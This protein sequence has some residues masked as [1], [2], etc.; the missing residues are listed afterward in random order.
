L[1]PGIRTGRDLQNLA[2][3]VNGCLVAELAGQCAETRSPGWLVEYDQGFFFKLFSF[4]FGRLFDAPKLHLRV[5]GHFF[6]AHLGHDLCLLPALNHLR[7]SAK[8]PSGGLSAADPIVRAG[9]QL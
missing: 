5:T 8:L 2:E 1:Q 9:T 6:I 7:A 3:P 4:C